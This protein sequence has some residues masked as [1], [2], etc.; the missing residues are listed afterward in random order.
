MSVLPVRWD[1]GVGAHLFSN[2]LVCSELSN[3]ILNLEN[4]VYNAMD[5]ALKLQRDHLHTVSIYITC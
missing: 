5:I 3:P 1:W 4:F 2:G